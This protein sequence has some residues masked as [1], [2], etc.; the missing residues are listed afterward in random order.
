MKHEITTEKIL[1]AASKCSQAKETLKILFPEA[2]KEDKYFDLKS[3]SGTISL[4]FRGGEDLPVRIEV[5]TTGKFENKGFYLSTTV[6][7]NIERDEFGHKIL[8]PTKIL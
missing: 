6:D 7:W 1:E 4:Q 8:V 2:F 3:K 5:R